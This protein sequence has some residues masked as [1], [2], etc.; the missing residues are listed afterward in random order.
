MHLRCFALHNLLG[1]E[2]HAQQRGLV[3][4]LAH[5]LQ[6]DGQSLLSV[7][8][9]EGDRGQTRQI[10]GGDEAHDLDGGAQ[11]RL[12]IGQSAFLDL[13]CCDS[14]GGAEDDI[15]VPEGI[16]EVIDHACADAL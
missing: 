15:H 11:V 5:H 14:C 16:V 3:P 12:T 13:W 7:A 8:N 4:S 1:G 6:A 9:R 2:S 10:G